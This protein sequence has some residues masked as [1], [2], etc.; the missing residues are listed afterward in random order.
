MFY[1]RVIAEDEITITQYFLITLTCY[2]GCSKSLQTRQLSLVQRRRRHT[3]NLSQRETDSKPLKLMEDQ[4]SNPQYDVTS[5]WS[6]TEFF[7]IMI[8]LSLSLFP[9]QFPTQTAARERQ[10]I[11]QEEKARNSTCTWK[12]PEENKQFARKPSCKGKSAATNTQSH[13]IIWKSLISNEMASRQKL[14]SQMEYK[15]M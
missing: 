4:R 7:N 6:S 13:G 3:Q 11:G 5:Q 14:D 8:L 15:L 9:V 2:I 12:K 10:D 1:F